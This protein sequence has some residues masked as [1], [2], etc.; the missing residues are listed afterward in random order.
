MSKKEGFDGIFPQ[1]TAKAFFLP[2]TELFSELFVSPLLTIG[3]S[4]SSGL[5]KPLLPTVPRG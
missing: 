4:V 1:N 2:T 5:T 3:G